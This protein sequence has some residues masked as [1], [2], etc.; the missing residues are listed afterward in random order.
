MLRR[1]YL[2]KAH[3]MLQGIE[4]QVCSKGAI[5][6]LFYELIQRFSRDALDDLLE[7]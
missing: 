2:M 7:Q 1:G 6:V 3:T 5:D 4:V